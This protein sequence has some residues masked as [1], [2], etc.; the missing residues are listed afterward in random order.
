MH[1]L[2]TFWIIYLFFIL[3]CKTI[4]FIPQHNQFD[5]VKMYDYYLSLNTIKFQER[6][7]IAQWYS[8]DI[9]W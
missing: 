8:D 3:F 4:N 7:N 2:Y 6:V 1:L 9:F 5:F